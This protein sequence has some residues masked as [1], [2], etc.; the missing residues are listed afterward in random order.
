MRP[1]KIHAVAVVLFALTLA[2]AIPFSGANA[3]SRAGNRPTSA[4]NTESAVNPVTLRFRPTMTPGTSPLTK[5]QILQLAQNANRH[6]IV[7]LKNQVSD[8]TGRSHHMLARRASL[9]AEVQ[10][11]VLHELSQVHAGN[12]MAFHII[13]AIRATVSPAEEAHLRS[14]PAVEAVVADQ[15]VQMA[16]LRAPTDLPSPRGRVRSAASISCPTGGTTSLEPQALEDTHTAYLDPTV[17][18]AQSLATG[19]GVTVAILSGPIDPYNPD[20]IRPDGTP[21]ITDYEDFTGV[22]FGTPAGGDAIE[23][24]LDMS[25]V[26]AQGNEVYNLNDYGYTLNN[27][28]THI[29]ILGMAPGANVMWLNFDFGPDSSAIEG[30]QYAVDNGAS[31]ISMSFGSNPNSDTTVDPLEMAD[32]SAEKDGLTVVVSSGDAGPGGSIGTPATDPGAIAVGASTT[33]NFRLQINELADLP[34]V[35]GVLNDNVVSFSSSGPTE[36]GQKTVDVVAPG[37][38]GWMACDPNP[39]QYPACANNAGLPS[40]FIAEGGTSES[41]PLDGRRGCARH[42]SL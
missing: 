36:N 35:K 40:P 32:Q 17:P 31:V 30:V 7:V 22:P 25:S 20:F 18:Q 38:F 26:A 34:G 6:V 8:L 12:V 1:P 39:V 13:D 11:P 14:D 27:D 16:P 5:S 23:S 15:R 29:R 24:F 42:R 10:R 9:M 41:A 28:C 19:K 33:E 37:A 21:V 4:G 2:A 3:A